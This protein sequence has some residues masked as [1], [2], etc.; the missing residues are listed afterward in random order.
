MFKKKLKWLLLTA[1]ITYSR[2]GNCQ[3]VHSFH[4]LESVSPALKNSFVKTTKTIIHGDT[5]IQIE[6]IGAI[7][8]TVPVPDR[9][10]FTAGGATDFLIFNNL[11]AA[12]QLN[13]VFKLN[14]KH[15][16]NVSAGFNMSGNFKNGKPD[17]ITIASNFFPDIGSTAFLFSMEYSLMN[18]GFKMANPDWDI[19]ATCEYS[20][21]RRNVV[22]T[23]GTTSK[24]TTYSFSL[25]NYNLGL[26]ARWKHTSLD[27]K[28]NFIAALAVSPK[29]T[30]ELIQNTGNSF[31]QV[32]YKDYTG[33]DSRIMRLKYSGMSAVLSFEYNDA[34][35]YFRTF[36][37]YPMFQGNFFFSIGIKAT[38]K[39]FSF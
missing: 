39:F 34:L 23:Q 15:A 32:Y 4:F 12:G 2:I 7:A 27:K 13:A 11:S 18:K 24:D 19:L 37:A 26:T 14:P 10:F 20:V 25:D 28:N 38:A 31:K 8:D 30:V 36:D 29:N 3:Q 22:I 21:Q 1:F 5:T 35:F 33:I 9:V 16:W 17:S 6:T